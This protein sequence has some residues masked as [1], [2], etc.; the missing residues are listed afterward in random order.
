MPCIGGLASAIRAADLWGKCS[1]ALECEQSTSLLRQTTCNSSKLLT[2]TDKLSSI[3]LNRIG[4]PASTNRIST[5]YIVVVNRSNCFIQLLYHSLS[6]FGRRVHDRA[7]PRVVHR[8]CRSLAAMGFNLPTRVLQM[9][10]SP[11]LLLVS[12]KPPITEPLTSAKTKH[13]ANRSI[14]ECPCVGGLTTTDSEHSQRCPGW[15]ASWR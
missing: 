14:S 6:A 1:E 5:T 8:Q 15:Q 10:S 11:S 12:T 9:N 4:F 3:Q 13:F 2:F 7:Y